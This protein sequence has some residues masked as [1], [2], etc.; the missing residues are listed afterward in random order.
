MTGPTDKLRQCMDRVS[1]QTNLLLI[2]AGSAAAGYLKVVTH[3]KGHL[4]ENGWNHMI[5]W[6]NKLRG[7]PVQPPATGMPRAVHRVLQR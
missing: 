3:S 5:C 1:I 7:L 6:L 2:A 4:L